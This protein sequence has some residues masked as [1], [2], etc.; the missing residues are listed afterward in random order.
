MIVYAL[1]K[2]DQSIA[3]CL[4]AA[5]TVPSLRSRLPQSGSV[6]TRCVTGFSHFRCEPP[7]RR[8]NS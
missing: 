8:G 1:S 4:I 5:R 6:V 2:S 7:P 3:N